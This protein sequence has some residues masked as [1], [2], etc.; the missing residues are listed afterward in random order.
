MAFSSRRGR[1]K[2]TNTTKDIG[3]KE[4]RQKRNH[5]QT[6]EPLDL[7][8]EKGILSEQQHWCGIHLRWLYTLRYGAP[9]ISCHDITEQH[10]ATIR[11]DDPKWRAER[12]FEYHEAANYLRQYGHYETVMNLAVFHELPAFM[13]QGLIRKAEKNAQLRVRLHSEHQRLVNGFRCLESLWCNYAN[14]QKS[15]ES[16]TSKHYYEPVL[17]IKSLSSLVH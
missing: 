7:C 15:G 11:A 9:N 12:E 16:I 3:T 6:I 1:P 4:L 5:M 2:N 10:H 13:H 14:T 8:M 17:D